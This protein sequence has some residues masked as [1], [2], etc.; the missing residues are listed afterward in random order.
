M[1]RTLKS[2]GTSAIDHLTAV[3]GFYRSNIVLSER[4]DAFCVLTHYVGCCG[5]V[6]YCDTCRQYDEVYFAI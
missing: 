4:R 6:N 5:F 3:F 1:G 2:L